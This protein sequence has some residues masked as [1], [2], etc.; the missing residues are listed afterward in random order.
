[1]VVLP[2]FDFGAVIFT[3]GAR[4]SQYIYTYIAR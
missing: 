4:L 3:C 1:M 2:P